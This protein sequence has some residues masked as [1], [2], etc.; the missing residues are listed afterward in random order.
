M[1]FRSFEQFTR[2]SS[3][4][5]HSSLRIC[6][7]AGFRT[8]SAPQKIRKSGAKVPERAKNRQATIPTFDAICGF[9]SWTVRLDMFKATWMQAGGLP[10]VLCASENKKVR[11][12]NPRKSKN[13]QAGGYFRRNAF[14]ALEVKAGG[15]IKENRETIPTFDAISR[16]FFVNCPAWHDQSHVTA[17]RRASERLMRLRK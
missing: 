7:P 12:K 1:E 2:A 15:L 14:Q 16:V 4:C 13:R 10:N 5:V 3:C 8:S 6:K 17:S 11:C 9:F